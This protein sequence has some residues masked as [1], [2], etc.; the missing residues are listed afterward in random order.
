MGRPPTLVANVLPHTPRDYCQVTA[1]TGKGDSQQD[2]GNENSGQTPHNAFTTP[3]ERTPVTPLRR[4]LAG[5]ALTA[6]L[7]AAMA[8][9]AVADDDTAWGAPA[10]TTTSGGDESTDDTGWGTPPADPTPAPAEP[11]G[12]GARPADTAWG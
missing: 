5:A 1:A 4:L 11:T 8:T 6:A 12:P 2:E 9:T 3:S 10:T 7:T